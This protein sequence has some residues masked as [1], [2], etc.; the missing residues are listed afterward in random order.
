[1]TFLKGSK[2]CISFALYH[3]NVYSSTCIHVCAYLHTS[4]CAEV[5]ILLQYVHH[6]QQ[7]CHLNNN[8]KYMFR[9]N[10]A[11]SPREILYKHI[12]FV[13]GNTVISIKQKFR[14]FVTVFLKVIKNS[15][16]H[17]SSLA[18]IIC[19]IGTW[20]EFTFHTTPKWHIF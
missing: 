17:Y 19:F 3:I 6:E 14:F 12:V 18:Y 8:P 9:S 1:M 4:S 5:Y 15:Q 10:V 20:Q 2:C 7:K 11:D 16:L 13:L